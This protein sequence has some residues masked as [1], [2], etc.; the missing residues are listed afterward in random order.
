MS[1]L[2][3]IQKIIGSFGMIFVMISM[4]GL[5]ILFY[6]NG[7]NNEAINV[8]DWLNSNFTVTN[9]SKDVAQCQRNLYFVINTMGTDQ[10]SGWVEKLNQNIKDIDK[11]FEHY[12]EV[13]SNCV[14][15]TEEERQ[16]DLV[17]LNQEVAVWQ[18]YK[19]TV[20]QMQ[21]MTTSHNR[22]ECMAFMDS[23]VDPA[24]NKIHDAIFKDLDMCNSGL[25]EAVSKSEVQAKG[26]ETLVHIVG[27]IIAA[28]LVFLVGI[29]YILSR[30]IKKSVDKIVSVTEKAAQGDLSQDIKVET[31]DEFGKI[32][33][34]FNSVMKHMRQALGEVQRAAVQVSDS[35]DKVTASIN[36]TGDLVQNVAMSVTTAAENTDSQKADISETEERVKHMEQSIEKSVKAMQTGLKSVQQT[37]QQADKG[38][39]TARVTVKQMNDISDAVAESAKIVEELG[40]NSKE[41]GSIVAVISGIAEQTNLLALNAAIEAAR[42]GAAGRG[43]SVVADEVR[44]LAENSQNS[45]QQIGEIIEKIQRTTENAVETMNVASQQVAEGR[46]NVESTG[47]SFSEIVNM[48]KIAEENSR[49]VMELIGNMKAPIADI[50]ERTEK[51]S[52]MSVEIAAKMEEI[53][54]ATGE[55]SMSVVEIFENSGSL[56]D[57]AKNLENTV[58][59]FKL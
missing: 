15:D 20:Q 4:L 41:I 56:N 48:I 29:V 55:Q 21:S 22:A 49:Q 46:N 13:L 57:L 38:N 31:E 36:K 47:N 32:A 52:N 45:A 35:A 25:E 53:S 37:L 42:A 59:E 17:I 51:L 16:S 2:S 44:K 18:S 27:I 11:G 8:R 58:H 10:N 40:E 33:V 1:K 6:F 30:D 14:Y 26:F 9:I 34:Q 5:F 23:T 39:E 28:I 19:S 50:V 43:F 7:I 3:V 12:A 54:M 24:Y